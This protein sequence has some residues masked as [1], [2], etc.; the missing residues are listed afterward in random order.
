VTSPTITD[1]A[2]LKPRNFKITNPSDFVGGVS[3]GTYGLAAMTLDRDGLTARKSVFFFDREIAAL[4]A[5]ISNPKDSRPITSSINQ[6]LRRGEIRTD[7]G[8]VREGVAAYND[9]KWAWHDQVGYVFPEPLP[10]RLGSRQQEGKWTEISSGGK[11]Q[12]T[13][14]KDIFSLWI[15][16]GVN[17]G[18]AHY[19]Y[20]LLP[21][22]SLEETEKSAR[23]PEITILSNTASLQAV[24]HRGLKLIQ[25]VFYEP[26]T[27]DYGEGNTIAVNKPCALLFHEG[28]KKFVVSD[29]TQLARELTV[30]LNGKPATHTLPSGARAGSSLAVSDH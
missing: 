22:A 18:D 26:G 5:G 21:G 6:S 14:A 4:G 27:L 2:Q 7:Q 1:K 16:H 8:T 19:S 17:P 10:L 3:D 28:T 12:D 20:I 23:A 11:N 15:D 25:A 24:R 30:T 29:P 9:L 13:V